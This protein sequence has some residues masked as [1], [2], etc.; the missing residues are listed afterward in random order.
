M[1][2]SHLA[3]R[4]SDW[5]LHKALAVVSQFIC[6]IA[7]SSKRAGDSSQKPKDSRSKKTEERLTG[8]RRR[9][10]RN[11]F[12]KAKPP[13]TG[14]LQALFHTGREL[15]SVLFPFRAVFFGKSLVKNGDSA[16]NFANQ[17]F[18]KLPHYHLSVKGEESSLQTKLR[19]TSKLLILPVFYRS[20]LIKFGQH[21]QFTLRCMP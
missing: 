9:R 7:P 4:N 6:R 1:G 17:R 13:L 10:V 8:E 14:K 18:A 21:Q 15:S 20:R 2:I 16:G 12:I 3:F 5:P 19:T 11:S